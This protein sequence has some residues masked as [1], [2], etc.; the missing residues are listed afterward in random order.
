[1][2]L[3]EL[4]EIPMLQ[5]RMIFNLIN[6]RHDLRGLQNSLEILLQEIRHPDRLRLS[7]GVDSFQICPFLLQ[8]LVG[9]GE[10]GRVDQVL[11]DVL[12]LQLLERQLECF[13]R[14]LDFGAGD[15]GCN[16]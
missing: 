15:L 10:E 5:V 7:T 14:V 12:Q 1:M 3:V 11:V 9:S 4:N 2:L 6:R 16:V 13:L 8:V